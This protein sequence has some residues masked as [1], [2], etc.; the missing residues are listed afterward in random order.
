MESTRFSR[1]V[2]HYVAPYGHLLPSLGSPVPVEWA[3]PI[4]PSHPDQGPT[5]FSF[6]SLGDIIF[7][8]THH[9]LTR[10]YIRSVGL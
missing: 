2:S 1:R 5:D 8:H 3:L 9:P 6:L 10:L 4:C 7:I